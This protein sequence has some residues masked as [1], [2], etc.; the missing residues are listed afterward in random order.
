MKT[1]CFWLVV[2]VLASISPAPLSLAA[3]PSEPEFE[4]LPRQDYYDLLRKAERA[5]RDK[6]STD[7]SE[8][9]KRLACAGNQ[10]SQAVLASLYFGGQGIGKDDLAGYAWLKLASASGLPRFKQLVETLDKSMTADQRATAD[11][12][13]AALQ[14]LYGPAAT[15][16]TCTKAEA[17]GS[18]MQ[19]LRCEPEHVN[20]TGTLVWLKRC[21]QGSQP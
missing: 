13:V 6:G 10:A 17:T 12:K 5:T 18:H 19:E 8:L 4:S 11:A 7:I 21:V 15:H 16:M 2:G 3:S 14:A 1:K 9:E 20:T